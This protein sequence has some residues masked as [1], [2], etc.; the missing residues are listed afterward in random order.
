M[1]LLASG[2]DT[3]NLSVRGVIREPVWDL[4]AEVQRRARDA[5]TSEL[6]SFPV[7]GRPSSADRSAGG[8]TRTGYPRR[9][10]S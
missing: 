4:L 6:L 10:T 9:T 5:E 3:L 1:K 2:I 8:G 7:T